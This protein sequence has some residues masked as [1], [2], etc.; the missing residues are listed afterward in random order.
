MPIVGYF[1]ICERGRSCS[2]DVLGLL[3]RGGLFKVLT[4]KFILNL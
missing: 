3:S 1:G 2:S 4:D